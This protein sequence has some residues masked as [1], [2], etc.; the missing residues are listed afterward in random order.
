M[1]APVALVT[2]AL[3]GIGKAT[4]LAFA[5]KGYNVVVSGRHDEAGLALAQEV[6]AL[7][8]E[9]EFIKADVRRDEEVAGLVDAVIAR[10]GKI[11]AAVNNADTEGKSGPSTEQAAQS[12]A[13]TFD[14]NMPGAL[15]SIRHELRAMFARQSD[16]IVNISSTFGSP[17]GAGA[18]VYV[19]SNHAEA[20]PRRATQSV[21]SQQATHSFLEYTLVQAFV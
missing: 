5:R 10:F 14:T 4:A 13:M 8:V 17:R 11:D 2:G 21:P 16:S 20:I 12:F 3:T 6:R 15:L 7:G 9:A 1:N 18:S 19:A